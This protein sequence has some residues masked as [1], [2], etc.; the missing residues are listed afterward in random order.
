MASTKKPQKLQKKLKTA[1]RTHKK[2]KRTGIIL[3]KPA[4]R[5]KAK[6]E[7]LGRVKKFFQKTLSIAFIIVGSAFIFEASTASLGLDIK[8][9]FLTPKAQITNNF[10]EPSKS[11]KTLFIPKLSRTLAVSD[12]EVINNRWSISLTGV[13]F[14]KTSVQPGSVGN[15]VLYGH[16]LDNILGDLYLVGKGDSIYVVVESGNFAKYEVVETKEVTSQSVE[17]LNASQD[18]RLTL[19]TCSGFLDSARFVVIARQTNFI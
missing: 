19:Y 12:G 8:H 14:L 4:S 1:T 16:N 13:S 17:I 6:N 9:P 15:S 2:L 10:T 3:K 11:P 7:S 18:S 5:A